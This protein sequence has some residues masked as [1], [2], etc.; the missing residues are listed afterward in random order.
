[1]K[2][3]RIFFAL[4]FALFLFAM[5][6][7]VYPEK[8]QADIDYEMELEREAGYKD[9]YWDGNADGYKEGYAKGYEIGWEDC[10]ASEAYDDTPH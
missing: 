7:C 5:C 2:T 6:G 10:Y 3:S 9:G 1:M 8:D 4:F